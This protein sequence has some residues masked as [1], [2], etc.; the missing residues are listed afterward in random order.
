[1]KRALFLVILLGWVAPALTL[2]PQKRLAWDHPGG[3]DGFLLLVWDGPANSLPLEIDIPGGDV[4]EYKLDFT[5]DH[6]AVIAMI[7]Y[8]KDAAGN[9]VEES[10]ES[11]EVLLNIDL[12]LGYRVELM[13]TSGPDDIRATGD[14][15]INTRGGDDIV[16]VSGTGFAVLCLGPGSDRAFLGSGIVSAGTGDDVVKASGMA[17]LYGNSGKDFLEG[18]WNGFLVGGSD[19][20]TCKGGPNSVYEGCEKTGSPSQ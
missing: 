6:G 19:Q 12:C 13:G 17:T 20:D 2:P 10:P 11:N 4:R 14:V 15:V 9:I 3:A 16:R 8:R 7:A 18:G 1:M 5:M